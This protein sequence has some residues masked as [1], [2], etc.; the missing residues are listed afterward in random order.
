MS[1]T[2]YDIKCPK[3]NSKNRFK[4]NDELD[5]KKIM[6]VINREVFHLSCKNCHQDIYVEYPFK[7]SNDKF[8]IYYTPTKK[9]EI[10][11]TYHEYMRVCDTF[12]DLK[13]KLLIY[14]DNLNDIII[15][16]IKTFLLDKMDDE[17]KDTSTELRYNGID[18][19]N[20]LFS[21]IDSDKI[22]GCNKVF[23]DNLKKKMKIKK[24]K[25][26]ILID[27]DTYQKYYKMRLF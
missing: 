22:I 11:S 7:I 20:I 19:E 3:C 25:K 21:I 23:Y 2:K 4:V 17:L 15:E 24:I 14:N 13:E 6:D 10:A 12:T 26:C 27:K 9:D 18:G 16:F 1:I 5:D 8:L